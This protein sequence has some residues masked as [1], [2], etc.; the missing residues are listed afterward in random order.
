M[1]K[2]AKGS[3]EKIALKCSECNRRNYTTKKNKKICR[4]NGNEKVLQM[5]Q[6]TYSA[7]RNKIK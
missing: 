5:G 4:E 2:K 7:C 1:A 6:Q 3:V